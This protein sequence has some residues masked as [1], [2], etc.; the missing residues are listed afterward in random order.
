MNKTKPIISVLAL[1]FLLTVPAY[2]KTPPEAKKELSKMDIEYTRDNFLKAAG[3]GDSTVL[4]LFLDA[5]MDLNTAN[6][7]GYTTLHY[8]IVGEQKSMTKTLILKGADVNAKNKK[9]VTPLIF[10]A[11]MGD[12]EAVKL[13]LEKGADVNA[14]ESS[15]GVTALHFASGKGHKEIV[16]I[17]LDK[18]ADVNAKLVSGETALKWATS[19]GH[20]DIV[21]LLKKASNKNALE[22][23]QR[24]TGNHSTVEV[25]DLAD[26]WS[27]YMGKKVLVKGYAVIQTDFLL[28]SE[29]KCLGG[30]DVHLDFETNASTKD[31]IRRLRRTPVCDRLPVALTVYVHGSGPHKMSVTDIRILQP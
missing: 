24:N 10:A 18:G 30:I 14:K 13:L 1:F 21:A 12:I 7:D 22:Q 11:D 9:G 23:N 25:A 6:E 16:K 15:T 29:K 28:L 31:A 5:G 20:N 19:Y 4:N 3:K 27:E 2:S 17:L 8:S 26:S